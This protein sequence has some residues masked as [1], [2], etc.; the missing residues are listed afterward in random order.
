MDEEVDVYGVIPLAL[1]RDPCDVLL[2]VIDTQLSHLKV[3]HLE[4]DEIL[5]SMAY[6]F[7]HSQSKILSRFCIP[8]IDPQPKQNAWSKLHEI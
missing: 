8:P 6:Y 7:C 4:S 3:K 2:D 1:S 5:I